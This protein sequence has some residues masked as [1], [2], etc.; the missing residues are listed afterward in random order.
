MHYYCACVYVKNIN[1]IVGKEKNKVRVLQKKNN[2]FLKKN[3]T[4]I[5]IFLVHYLMNK[6]VKCC[7]VKDLDVF[8]FN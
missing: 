6:N 4:L 5:R 1:E 3:P 7:V 8:S 2:L